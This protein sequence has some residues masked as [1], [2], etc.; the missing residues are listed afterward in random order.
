MPESFWTAT[1]LRIPCPTQFVP[2]VYSYKEN[3]NGKIMQA[4]RFNISELNIYDPTKKWYELY[5]V[6]AAADPWYARFGIDSTTVTNTCNSD[7]FL[8]KTLT[9]D[10]PNAAIND[11]F[12]YELAKEDRPSLPFL[13]RIGND[14]ATFEN[15]TSWPWAACCA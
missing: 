13:R 11:K 2:E 4:M 9:Q 7:D 5:N 3:E 8:T 15:L 6:S 14:K 10:S 1:C 12:D